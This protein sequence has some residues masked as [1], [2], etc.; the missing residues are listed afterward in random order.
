M[1]S[2]P[3]IVGGSHGAVVQPWMSGERR[4]DSISI[5][6]GATLSGSH[7]PATSNCLSVKIGIDSALNATVWRDALALGAGTILFVA[8]KKSPAMQITGL[9]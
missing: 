9:R 8:Q 2:T 3:K 4:R 6:R 5:Y 7:D 1:P